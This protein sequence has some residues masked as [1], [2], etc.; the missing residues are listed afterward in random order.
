MNNDLPKD[1]IRDAVMEKIKIDHEA[2]RPKWHFVLVSALVITGLTLGVLILVFTVSFV[3]F[4]LDDGGSWFLPAFGLPG[5]RTFFASLPWLL[6]L[7]SALLVVLLEILARHF[8][9]VY[10]R[11]LLYFLLAVIAVITAASFAVSCTPL[12]KKFNDLAAEQ[13]LPLFGPLYRDFGPCDDC[14]MQIGT[15]NEFTDAGFFINDRRGEMISVIVTPETIFPSG[16]NFQG[17]DWVIIL[18][19]RSDH[20]IRAAGVN[21]INPPRPGRR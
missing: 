19:P 17:G 10:R 20:T 11:P 5:F 14:G 2:M 12:H 13:K 21:L 3:F 4:T 9:F 15:I 7:F 1:S 6:I 8:S 18:G 16:I